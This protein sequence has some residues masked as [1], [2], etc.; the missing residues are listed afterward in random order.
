M[1]NVPPSCRKTEVRHIA[2]DVETTG[3]SPQRGDRVIEIGAVVVEHGTIVE[4]F[5]TLIQIN[6]RIPLQAQFI[7]GI[8]NEMLIGMPEPEEVF[9]RF[10]EFVRDRVLIAH[11][12]QF[13]IGFLRAEYERLGIGCPMTYHCTMELSRAIFPRLKNHKLE[14]VYRHLF[15]KIDGREQRHRA[16]DDARMVARMWMEMMKR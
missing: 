11:N 4:E 14:T 15:G 7:H 8:T 13:D 3:L 2:L 5:Q 16:L 6:K 1:K 9:P 10:K 12:A